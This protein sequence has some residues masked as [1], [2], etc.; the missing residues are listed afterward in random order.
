MNRTVLLVVT[1]VVSLVT[2]LVGTVTVLLIEDAVDATTLVE[3]A[4]AHAGRQAGVQFRGRLSVAVPG[5]G[6]SGDAQGTSLIEGAT[7][8]TDTRVVARQD[9]SWVE[10]RQIDGVVYQR[11]AASSRQ[12]REEQFGRFDADTEADAPGA[13]TPE[14]GPGTIDVREPARIREL[15]DAVTGPEVAERDGDRYE[16]SAVVDGSDARLTVHES[17][18][19]DRVRLS[20]ADGG[21]EVVSDQSYF[22]W[23]EPVTVTRPGPDQ[24]DPTPTVDEEALAGWTASPLYS[25]RSLPRGWTL[26][27]AGVLPEELTA[28]RCEQVEI[29]YV[30]PDDAEAGYLSLFQIPATCPG[31]DLDPPDGARPFAAGPYRGWIDEDGGDGGGLV[32][33]RVGA[34]IVQADTDLDLATLVTVLTSLA[35]LDLDAPTTPLTVRGPT[36]S[37]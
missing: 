34:T 31:L 6:G 26:E 7:D 14:E 13:F 22:A 16:L 37:A 9:D 15:L 3:R 19:V 24:I 12:L 35:P 23:G 30:D 36:T 1:T 25:P 32:Q 4:R 17:G 21:V 33:I 20:L 29:D 5:P 10:I 8:F 18:R 11:E 27:G 28:E 2:A